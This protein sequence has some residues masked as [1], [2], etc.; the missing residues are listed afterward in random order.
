MIIKSLFYELVSNK[1]YLSKIRTSQLMIKRG[2]S[3]V[4]KHKIIIIICIDTVRGTY[5]QDGDAWLIS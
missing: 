5:D 4:N 3:A 2:P 1:N